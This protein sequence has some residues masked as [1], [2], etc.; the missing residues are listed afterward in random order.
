MASYKVTVGNVGTVIETNSPIEAGRIYGD[1]KEQS[2]K[3]YGRAAYET[4]IMWK[5][6][7]PMWTHEG[8][9]DME[10]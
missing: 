4:V 7:E 1:Y 6:A 9:Q 3:G 10:A 2:I 5:D 8:T